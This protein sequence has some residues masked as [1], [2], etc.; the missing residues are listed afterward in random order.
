MA[1]AR[2]RPGLGQRSGVTSDD[3]KHHYPFDPEPFVAEM[4]AEML[5]TKAGWIEFCRRVGER[6]PLVKTILTAFPPPRV[7][8]QRAT[9]TT[10][11]SIDVSRHTSIEEE[12][13]ESTLTIV[14]SLTDPTVAP[15]DGWLV[16]ERWRDVLIEVTHA[17]A[18]SR[19]PLDYMN[20]EIRWRLLG[21]ADDCTVHV[22]RSPDMFVMT[23]IAIDEAS[24]RVWIT[25]PWWR[26]DNDA[27]RLILERTLDAARRGCDVRVITRPPRGQHD[28]ASALRVIE[29]LQSHRNA[30]VAFNASEHAKVYIA[31]DVSVLGSANLTWSD[32]RNENAVTL[33]VG[34]AT[35]QR[36][37]A[38]QYQ[39]KGL[40]SA[41]PDSPRSPRS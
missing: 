33:T 31:D 29:A 14:V 17:W 36:T 9:A 3:Q 21:D 24:E 19:A 35:R 7:W 2:F 20:V 6:N 23:G 8:W 15:T 1:G 30:R 18:V 22:D 4:R 37:Q 41:D 10:G 40:A 11:V 39:W 27:G 12:W 16:L 26:D 28:E 5:T 38:F 13:D 32:E 34:Q 25:V